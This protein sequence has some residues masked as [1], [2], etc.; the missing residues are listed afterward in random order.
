[1]PTGYTHEIGEG[2]TFEKFAMSCAR[3][4]G[5]LVTMRDDPAD[6]EIPDEFAPDTKYYDGMIEKAHATLSELATMTDAEAT[7]NAEEAYRAELRSQQE[8][9]DKNEALRRKYEAML[10]KVCEWTP[11]TPDHAG[12]KR[13]MRE[14]IEGSIE[15]DCSYR[16]DAP[17][18]AT[19]EEYKRALKER[20][21]RDL[22]YGTA[23]RIKEIERAN[24]RTAWVR[25]LRASLK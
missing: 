6:A 7:A 15:F 2:A 22:E 17:V 10:E 25:A 8:R 4:F 3:N 14:Q 24:S 13:F 19:P 5:A 21:L 11:P 9:M 1:M 12:L 20:A 18:L 23:E 16:D